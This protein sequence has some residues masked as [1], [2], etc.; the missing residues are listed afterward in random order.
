MHARGGVNQDMAAGGVFLLAGLFMLVAGRS[1][2]LG[3]LLRVG[4]G[5]LPL[6]IGILLLVVGGILVARGG[7]RGAPAAEAIVLRPLAL[8]PLAIFAF[9]QMIELLGLV[10]T[11]SLVMLFA[12]TAGQE[13]RWREQVP[14]A[15]GAT[16]AASALFIHVLGLPMRYW[17]AF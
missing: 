17:P 8:I 7:L 1:Y 16:L 13:F 10:S 14:L 2:P 3:T 15:I 6:V 11:G 4:P 5:F 12:A 9:S